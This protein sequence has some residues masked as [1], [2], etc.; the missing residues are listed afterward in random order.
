V[1][2]ISS[3]PH[4][5]LKTPIATATRTIQETVRSAPYLIGCIEA[6]A[7]FDVELEGFVPLVELLVE[8]LLSPVDG[9]AAR[10]GSDVYD[11]VTPVAFW[12]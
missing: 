1:A 3:Y 6:A 9:I 7:P 12:H 10:V 2:S 5:N 4:K 8:L 11:I